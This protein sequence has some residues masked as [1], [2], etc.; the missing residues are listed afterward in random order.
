[1]PARLT[2]HPPHRATITVLL[3]EEKSAVI[4]RDP[5]CDVVLDDPRVSKRHATLRAEGTG[6]VLEDAGSKNGTSVDGRPAAGQP[7]LDGCW[8]SLGGVLG[9][10][11]R[12]SVEA[13][14]ALEDDRRQRLSTSVTAQREMDEQ[15]DPHGLLERL[16]RS[17]LSL[18]GTT[19]G[20]VL[21][22]GPDGRYLPEVAAGLAQADLRG[23]AFSGSLG[24]LERVIG[25]GRA[26]VTHDAQKDPHLASRDSV[27]AGGLRGLACVPLLHERRMLGILYVDGQRNDAPLTE[28]DLEI[29]AA[30]CDHAA[31]VLATRDAGMRLRTLLQRPTP[32]DPLIQALVQRLAVLPRPAP[33]T[34]TG[35]VPSS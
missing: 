35:L 17:A 16:L 4:G 29:L 31:I 26:V 20:F 13:L 32:T 24:A 14:R 10:F 22:A 6:W 25:T 23:G 34:E 9:R 5:E 28:L 1:V 2:L 18:T 15:K 27:I 21:V 8:V 19:R 12:L 7:L 30:L 11:E 33:P 3:H